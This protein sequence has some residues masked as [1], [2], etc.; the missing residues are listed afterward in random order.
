MDSEIPLNDHNLRTQRARTS[1]HGLSVGDAFGEQ[2]FGLPTR[3]NARLAE[4]LLPPPTW[5][6]TDDT[7]MAMSVV[8]VLE[9]QGHI[10]R[11][12]LPAL[13]AARLQA[14]PNRGYGAGARQLLRSLA[15][16]I[17]WR[18]LAPAMFGGAGS[19]G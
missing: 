14:E 5:P 12:A 9:Q 17:S 8:D 10:D 7:A 3:V 1:L 2:F 6:Y 13:F 16:G 11:E 15:D 18:E 4:R 19:H